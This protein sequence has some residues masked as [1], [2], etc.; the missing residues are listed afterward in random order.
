[1]GLNDD[2]RRFREVG[3]ERREDLAD[4]IRY[5]DL[6]R[7]RQDRV[8]IPIKIIDLPEFTYEWRDT[9]GVGQGEAEV[10]DSLGQPDSN[11]GGDETGEPGSDPSEHSYYDM[12]PA[13]FAAELEEELG[14]D[15]E[16]KGKEIVDEVEGEFSD[17]ARAGPRS[18]L[19]VEYLFRE[20]LKRKLAIDFDE[21]YVR[22]A[23]KVAGWGPDEVYAWTRE[24]RIPVSKRWIETTASTLSDAD[25]EYWEGIEEMEANVD[26]SPASHRIREKGVDRLP[27]RRQDERYR[28]PTVVKK[29]EQN[30]VVVNIRDVS[31]SMREEK[32][33]LVE[34]TFSPLDWYLQGKYDHAEFVYIAHDAEAWEVDREQFFGISSGGGTRIS[35]AYALATE[36]LDDEY[37]WAEWN[38]YVFAAGDSE[39]S[40]NDTQEHVVPLMEGLA[41]NRQ[42]YIETQPGGGSANATHAD[43]VEEYFTDTEDIIVSRVGSQDD[44]TDAI[45]AILRTEIPAS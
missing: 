27:F 42:A 28:H 19:D 4:F 36:I 39:N 32:R 21:E 12:D 45:T 31:G 24:K 15:L 30:V 3:E 34:R 11:G 29:R 13:E 38:R 18:T 10:G 35:S 7:S 23:L 43:E 26:R 33:D 2:L 17:I 44:V 1:M 40:R 9:G 6:G 14:L 16:P 5:G 25:R 8:R 41:V 20:G 22:E 37:P